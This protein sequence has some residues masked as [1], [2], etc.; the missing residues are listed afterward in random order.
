MRNVKMPQDPTKSN[1]YDLFDTADAIV[2]EVID[3]VVQQHDEGK[4][5]GSS[6]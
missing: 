3:N 6:S 4:E 5:D 1:P 2:H